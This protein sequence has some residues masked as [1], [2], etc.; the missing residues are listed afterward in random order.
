MKQRQILQ[1]SDA[2][3]RSYE[4]LRC[5]D[6]QSP[7]PPAIKNNTREETLTENIQPRQIIL[8]VP[9]NKTPPP[10]YCLANLFK[11]GARATKSKIKTDRAY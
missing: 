1:S 11:S 9:E 2:W 8:L 10:V 3:T 5:N 4:R 7:L 6:Y